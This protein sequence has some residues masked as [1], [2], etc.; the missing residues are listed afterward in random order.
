MPT[1]SSK[2]LYCDLILQYTGCIRTAWTNF[3]NEFP[4][5]KQGKKLISVYVRKHLFLEVEPPRSPEFNPFHISVTKA[6]LMPDK[7]HATDARHLNSC[8]TPRSE[9]SMRTLIQV[10][11]ILSICCQ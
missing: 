6:F 5:P 3:R 9:V 7:P 4:A 10:E 2:T 1:V 11:G 8:D